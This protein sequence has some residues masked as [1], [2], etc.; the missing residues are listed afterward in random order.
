MV[1][2]PFFFCLFVL[3]VFLKRDGFRTKFRLVKKINKEIRTGTKGIKR[4]CLKIAITN[5]LL[6]YGTLLKIFLVAIRILQKTTLQILPRQL[7]ILLSY[8]SL[9]KVAFR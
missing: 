1:L 8:L 4:E 3:F 5:S 9:C 2:Q 6:G 7:Q